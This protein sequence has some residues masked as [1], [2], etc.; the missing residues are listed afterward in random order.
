VAIDGVD[1]AGSPAWWLKR[2][3]GLLADRGRA[4]R[5]Q[6]LHDYYS[7]HAPLPEGAEN[8]REAFEAF[9]KKARTNF[10]E[11]VVAAVS[12][13]MSPI[14]F[15]TAA[16]SDETGDAEMGA[17]WE[18]AGMPVR[19]ADVHD[20]ML[21]LSEA[22]C[23]VGPMD[24][25]TGAPRVT[26]E[27]PRWTVGEPDPDDPRRLLAGLKV[28][29]DDTVNEDRGYLYLPGRVTDSGRAQVWVARR[30]AGVAAQS[31]VAGI[32]RRPR[33]PAVDF[34]PRGWEWVPERSGELP[35]PL[36]PMVRFP[37]KYSMGEYEHHVDLLDRI[38]HQI[39][40][41]LVIAVLQAHRQKAVKGLPSVYPAGHPKAG[42]E[43]DYTD[44]FTSDPASFWQLP[45][46]AELW[47][48]AT[49]DL[50]PIL[51]A[52]KDDVQQLGVV[53]RTPIYMMLPSG[54][55]QSAEG[56]NLQRE[57]LTSKVD[58]RIC[59]TTGQWAQVAA[60]MALHAGMPERADL[61]RLQ[62]MWAPTQRLSLAERADAAVKLSNVLPRRSM[63]IHVLG[64]SPAEADRI[65][66]EWEFDQ[67]VAAQTAQALA[68]A[69]GT[70]PPGQPSQP[71]QPQAE[72]GQPGQP[73]TEPPTRGAP[74]A[75][76]APQPASV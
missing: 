73:Q 19:A 44:M 63:L 55:N 70:A 25:E 33:P 59:R 10:G 3:F 16:D 13:R 4:R 49:T 47:E 32:G 52:I 64:F 60:V 26:S 40:M 67:L 17:L 9:Q 27:D 46:D 18:R 15:R 58:D 21:S 20:M 74:A 6:M 34:D 41:R 31:V 11:L 30:R 62:T 12:E 1:V 28:V 57:G 7:G 42:Q 71:G 23:I 56:A 50:R 51:E 65:M 75:T 54:V 37:N 45:A 24:R 29:Y 61:A 38:N 2:Q 53:T 69:G 48:S 14:G 76:G 8:A 36:M 35:H 39:L 66:S 43:I 5:L 68:G 22:Y 72:P